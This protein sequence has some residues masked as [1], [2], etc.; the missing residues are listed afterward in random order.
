MN[1][2][3]RMI[4]ETPAGDL[5]DFLVVGQGAWSDAQEDLNQCEEKGLIKRR[6]LEFKK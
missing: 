3:G 4:V 2:Q 1:P 6:K 5:W